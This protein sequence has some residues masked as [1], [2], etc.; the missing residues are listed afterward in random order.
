M[1]WT[2]PK[3]AGVLHDDWHILITDEKCRQSMSSDFQY[4]AV[5]EEEFRILSKFDKFKFYFMGGD[6]M[7]C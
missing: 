2:V 1:E 7:Q 3:Q 6:H 5:M 4:V